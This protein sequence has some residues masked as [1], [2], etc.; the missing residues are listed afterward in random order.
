MV[1]V[2][3]QPG[4]GI[5]DRGSL[6]VKRTHQHG[7]CN[8][9]IRVSTSDIG[10]GLFTHDVTAHCLLCGRMVSARLNGARFEVEGE[11]LKMLA[12]FVESDP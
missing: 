11:I 10:Q 3:Q 6:V 1:E 5:P 9:A 12:E 8:G 7:L 2:Y 4:G